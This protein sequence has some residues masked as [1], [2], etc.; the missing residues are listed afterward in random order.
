VEF[1]NDLPPVPVDWKF[2]RVPVDHASFTAYSHLSL[3]EV[4]GLSV[5]VVNPVVTHSL[6]APGFSL[7]APGFSLKPPAFSLKPPGFSLKPP[8]FSSKPPG[9]GFSLKPPGFSSKSPGFN[10]CAYEVKTW[11]QAFAFT[12]AQLVTA[13]ASELRKDIALPADLGITLDPMLMTQYQVPKVKAPLDPED[14]ALLDDG[15]V[16]LCR[17]NQVDP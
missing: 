1:K 15:E 3:D 17:L 5:Q 10:P 9:F 11:V 12:N 16:G 4:G 2:L 14:A 13:Y 8:A 6:K 7:K